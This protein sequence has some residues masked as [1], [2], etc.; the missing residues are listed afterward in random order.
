MTGELLCIVGVH[1]KFSFGLW[2]AKGKLSYEKKKIY[3]IFKGF[4][5]KKE[6]LDV[7]VQCS[8]TSQTMILF[9]TDSWITFNSAFNAV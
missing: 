6:V 3:L 5:D 1:G 4:L 8:K 2:K 9:S 7:L